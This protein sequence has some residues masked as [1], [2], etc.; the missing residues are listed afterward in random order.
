M[1]FQ[2]DEQCINKYANV[3]C[4]DIWTVPEREFRHECEF[5]RIREWEQLFLNLRE[6]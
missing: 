4:A 1:M 3:Y 5:S 6:L 2:F